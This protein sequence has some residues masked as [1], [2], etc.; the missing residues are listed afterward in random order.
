[1]KTPYKDPYNDRY[2]PR[3]SDILKLLNKPA[4]MY[5]SVNCCCDYLQ[6]QFQG[7]NNIKASSLFEKI[8]KARKEWQKVQKE[9]L[10]IGNQVHQAIHYFLTHNCQEPK[11][12]DNQVLNAFVAFLEWKDKNNLIPIVCEKI[13]YGKDYAGTT[14]LVCMLNNKITL[15]D[16]KSSKAVYDENW[17]QIAAYSN[18]WDLDNNPQIEQAGILR[19]DKKTGFPEWKIIEKEMLDKYYF[20]FLKL[21][22]FWWL[23]QKFKD[24]KLII[25]L[26]E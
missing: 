16:F 23:K 9:A 12:E 18:A 22:D 4:L 1:M 25:K 20:A 24:N 26:V 7:R 2:L 13:V 17:F 5:W 11:I 6:Q 19:L 8:E 10:D 21:V 15:I 3:V 14:D